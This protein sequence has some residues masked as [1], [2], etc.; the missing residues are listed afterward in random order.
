[1]A[2]S[3]IKHAAIIRTGFEYQDLNGIELLIAFYRDA[4]LYNWVKIEAD[5][6]KAGYIDD[7]VAERK[8]GTYEYI[9]VKFTP[10]PDKY[11]L[12]WD[13]LL[14][15]KPRGSSLLKKWSQSLAEKIP[16]GSVYSAELRTNRRPDPELDGA[17]VDGRIQLTR[18]SATR[19]AAVVSELGGETA[20]T[21]FFEKFRF[22]PSTYPDI[23]NYENRLK[24]MIVPSDTTSDGWLLLRSQVKRWATLKNQPEPDGKIL[25][26]HL[27]QI[28]TKQRPRPIPQN[29]IVPD[30]YAVPS[31]VFHTTFKR[32]ISAKRTSVAIVWGTPGRGKST[33]LSFLVRELMVSGLPV[34]RH[35]YFLSLDD[36]TADRISFSDIAFSLM[37]QMSARYPKAV[38]KRRLE[39]TPN[40]L[41]KW[42]TACA[43]FYA[44]KGKKFYV[45]I[46]GL[47]H[48]WREQQTIEQMN[49]LFNHLL[50]CPKNVVLLIGTQRV[51]DTQLPTKL[52]S[53]AKPNDWYEIPRMDEKA[54]HKWLSAQ[55]RAKRLRLGPR[56]RRTADRAEAINKLAKAF[57]DISKGHPLHLIY[58]FEALVRRGAIVSPA[59]VE[60]LPRCPDGD[61]RRYYR[62]LWGRIGPQGKKVVRLIA[63][64]DFRWP[65]SGL[66]Q[67]AGALDDID[68][69][70][71]HRR[72]GVLPFHGSILAFAREQAD[73][74][75]TFKS[76]LPGVIRWL[77]HDAPEYWRW[78][79]LWIMRARIGKPSELLKSTTRNWVIDSMTQ[80]WPDDQIASIL[81]EAES[82]AFDANDFSRTIEL[83]SLKH[84]VQNGPE[85]QIHQYAAF[86]ECS[87][88]AAGNRHEVLNLADD[89]GVLSDA[90]IA[91]LSRSLTAND[92]AEIGPECFDELARRVDIWMALRHRPGDE[93]LSLVKHAYEVGIRH[94]IFDASR[95]VKFLAGFRDASEIFISVLRNLVEAGDVEKLLAIRAACSD[96]RQQRW[97]SWVEDALV[98]AAALEA[99][100]LSTRLG[101]LKGAVTPLL[102]SW[103]LMHG[104]ACPADIRFDFDPQLLAKE[105]YEY[106]PNV[107][108]EK[109]FHGLFFS[110]IASFKFAAGPSSFVLPGVNV[111]TLGWVKSAIDT[112]VETA[113]SIASGAILPSFEA[114]YDAMATVE[115]VSGRRT[116][117]L[118]SAQY[119][120]FKA[121]LRQICLDLHLL[122]Q[123]SL[124]VQSVTA[125]SLEQARAS[126]H[127]N[128]VAWLN[129]NLQFRRTV[130]EPEAAEA[131][132]TRL[133]NCENGKVTTFNE[134]IELWIDFALFAL[135]YGLN[136]PQQF[137]RRA[138][139]GLVGYGYHK[140]PFAYDVLNS[141]KQVHDAGI[142]AARDMLIRVAP[143]I[144]Q[145]M[146]F[147]DGD[148]IR[149]AR[150]EIVELIA[151][152]CPNKLPDCYEH[153]IKN[154]KWELAADTLEA[155]VK[156]LDYE[157]EITKA[158]ARTFIDRR[159]ILTLSEL[160][161]EGVRG[162]RESFEQQKAFVGGVSPD[163][164][165]SHDSTL[166]TDGSRGR[167][168]DEA[169]YAPT[170][171][172]AF[173]DKVSD[174]KIGYKTS[175]AALD[176]WL[177]HWAD[178][179][180]APQA[181]KAIE[182]Y[183]ETS[184]RTY[185]VER[186]LDK[187]F[188]VSLKA[189][190]KA[191]AYK[192]LVRAHI[193]RNGWQSYWT[194]SEEVIRRLETAASI[195][196]D[197]W[198]EFIHDTSKQ[199][200]FY[201]NRGY[202]FTI[203]LRYL[204]RFL[205]LVGQKKIATKY[206]ETL[207]NILVEEV[208]DQPIP[209]LGW[210]Q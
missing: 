199:K 64:S 178:S 142:P 81:R 47:D 43:D 101:P 98:Q 149:G 48:V 72:T 63:G 114:I 151:A 186:I 162:A 203:G 41:R 180:K 127:W 181:L 30:S 24:G 111:G 104:Q 9:Q 99:V 139:D 76:L 118:D 196:R 42:I 36:T 79:W 122:A 16:T 53:A 191:A 138:S 18:L 74:T 182:R 194:S 59:E 95:C 66:R 78:A 108:L 131:F 177:Q 112:L 13:S 209:A 34:V 107:D 70:L 130:F 113:Q 35:H 175:E 19:R 38:E 193:A 11:F 31:E 164:E 4:A 135:L 153:H 202:G 140:D 184:D 3:S 176:A 10:D 123:D 14:A 61:I 33:Y 25:H 147:T 106:A 54:V 103:L 171:F 169:K 7:V 167:V 208:H 28:I 62:T 120:S 89:L 188:E 200:A 163:R 6:V 206:A 119:W 179:G 154:E 116:T 69:L 22:V 85:F 86:R 100:D 52:L 187:A 20:A 26:Y 92:E 157:D 144:D 185:F 126:P 183:F 94:G 128:D 73:H 190:G 117:E 133:S 152:I 71:E 207:A 5:D 161:T 32:R 1:M 39:D 77:E 45:V 15:K 57:F 84:R 132:L 110:A 109:F 137:V 44:T 58:S 159:E 46:D 198:K 189:Q 68:H 134:R 96:K 105:R 141:I 2:K 174:L 29:F 129:T 158:L 170:K 55:L 148:D 155:H 204:V 83:R 87:I 50:P 195:Y 165:Y 121:A 173:A 17:L 88:R 40:Q 27:V 172:A 145:I 67:C 201:E 125:A 124:N 168:P 210:L 160:A 56:S 156:L 75:S 97:R 8:N 150:G 60:G 82:V 205:L 146:E 51:A 143:I 166:D 102:A 90:E 197:R 136:D 65:E 115:P 37:D 91:A 80:G 192:W 93:F 23:E 21:A 12:D 49:H